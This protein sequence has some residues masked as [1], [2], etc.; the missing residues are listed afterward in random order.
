MTLDVGEFIRRAPSRAP[1]SIRVLG[2][3]PVAAAV[4]GDHSMGAVLAARHMLAEGRP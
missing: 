1:P 4:V 3:V 2:T